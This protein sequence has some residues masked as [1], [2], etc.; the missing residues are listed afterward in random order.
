MKQK[1]TLRFFIAL[2]IVFAFAEIFFF[3]Q[4]AKD[5]YRI[6]EDSNEERLKESANQHVELILHG[7]E[8][9]SNHLKD[10]ADNL[11]WSDTLTCEENIQY[12]DSVVKKQEEEILR[13]A[14]DLPNKM[15]YTSD[16]HILKI[17][18]SEY[19]DEVMQ[20][21]I[22]HTKIEKTQVEAGISYSTIIPIYKDNQVIAGLRC[23]YQPAH[24]SK[25]L[26]SSIFQ[27]KS[28]FN[29]MNGDGLFLYQAKH[30][31]QLFQDEMIQDTLNAAHFLKGAS[32]EQFLADI[33]AQKSGFV[34]ISLNDKEHELYY[35]PI[36]IQNW[37]IVSELPK[38]LVSA[39]S[40]DIQK[41][42]LI[43]FGK[44]GACFIA[45]S[46]VFF[47]SRYRSNNQLKKSNRYFHYVMN[48]VPSP[49]TIMDKD[50]NITF[51]NEAA[52]HMIQKD[53][54]EVVGKPCS[55]WKTQNCHT[56]NCAVCRLLHHKNPISS[57]IRD[58]C[59]YMVNSSLL[60]NE[61]NETIGF[62]ETFQNISEV[63][64]KE[65]ELATLIDN[66]PGG[67]L[68]CDDDADCTIQVMSDRFLEIVGYTQEEIRKDFHQSLS[69]MIRE[70]DKEAFYQLKQHVL[71]QKQTHF[72]THYHLKTKN[73]GYVSIYHCGELI[74]YHQKEKF[75][76][77]LIDVTEQEKIRKQL[78]EKN[79]ELR[80]ISE[81]M[82]G[83]MLVTKFDDRFKI[84]YTNAVFKDTFELD[85]ERIAQGVHL[86][87]FVPI[88]VNDKLKDEI[89]RQLDYKETIDVQYR[90]ISKN[91]LIW[92]SSKG[93]HIKE[94]YKD[95]QDGII[96][97]CMDISKEKKQN[98]EIRINA[99]RYRIAVSNTNSIVFDYLIKE[100]CIKH[101]N[102]MIEDKYHIPKC[103]EGI[104]QDIQ[105]FSMI[106]EDDRGVVMDC[107]YKVEL[108]EK[109]A[110][111]EFRLQKA[112]YRNRWFSLKLVTIF[113]DH[114]DPRKAVGILHDISEQKELE[115]FADKESTL[116]ATIL[117]DAIDFYVINLSRNKFV[118]GHERWKQ[119]M[120]IPSDDFDAVNSWIESEYVH[121]DD[122]AAFAKV[123]DRKR[124]LEH[125]EQGLLRERI[126]YRRRINR[127]SSSYI[128]VNTIIHLLQS[129]ESHDILAICNIQNV[130]EEKEKEVRLI[131]QAQKDLLS[132][133][134]NK[135]TTQQMIAQYLNEH[136]DT[137]CAFFLIDIDNFK[138]VNDT[139]GHAMGDEVIHEIS[140][141]ILTLFRSEDIAG[142]V[143]GDEFVVFMKHTIREIAEKKAEMLCEHLRMKVKGENQIVHI[144]ATIG[145]S[146]A[147]LHGI[148]F[149]SLYQHGDE[150]LYQVK[151]RGKNNY[152]FYG[153]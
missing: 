43:L 54:K 23:V 66:I 81:N 13:L 65:K 42:A 125:F 82:N 19:L 28:Y 21:K 39:Y 77:V 33:K 60:Q 45:L 75:C 80:Y 101:D 93:K 58:D 6:S 41:E 134:F 113:D 11:T 40:S 118:E 36:G 151:K 96:W 139:L 48:K 3:Y 52:L 83:M 34:N 132:G 128:W 56:Q 131:D 76:N 102:D 73:K 110:Y 35:A 135:V 46:A 63:I 136:P 26:N 105:K 30:E 144:S 71:T 57:F 24:L 2:F 53:L 94:Q 126:T 119:D 25:M 95:L 64:E 142:R 31:K 106:H 97:I 115:Q 61:K 32:Y 130:T 69:A 22:V 107:F 112:G 20:G 148:D 98:E 89:H 59:T 84:L 18:D 92:V 103:I 150:A 153:E 51:M 122:A 141:R 5:V 74:K 143:G 140:Q 149:T 138:H 70:D 85:D 87:D 72:E 117:K 146:L 14:I 124:L 127:Q 1:Q 79:L 109:Q 133:M 120:L 90:M 8:D 111:C 50:K 4:Y 47:Y 68:L 86:L 62:I 38:E 100:H 123:V 27:G 114:H 12:L 78:D 44:V 104:P 9:D 108:G 10:I 91:Q 7:L 99:E 137:S 67:V 37:Y 116:R 17:N 16:G 121:P 152:G 88:Q 29:V 129:K 147:P 49:I 55:I 145:I 15:T